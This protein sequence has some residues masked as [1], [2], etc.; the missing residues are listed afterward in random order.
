MR[1][2]TQAPNEV[3]GNT[4]NVEL[5]EYPEGSERS[6]YQEAIGVEINPLPLGNLRDDGQPTMDAP[7]PA[8]GGIHQNITQALYDV[9]TSI[10]AANENR[11]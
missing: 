7:C 10:I 2:S 3:P 6:V 9:S 4:G 11:T 1:K 5:L 8:T